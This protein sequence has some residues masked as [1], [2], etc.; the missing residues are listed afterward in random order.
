MEIFLMIFCNEMKFIFNNVEIL[1][2]GGF[3]GP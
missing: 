2:K 3:C 1:L